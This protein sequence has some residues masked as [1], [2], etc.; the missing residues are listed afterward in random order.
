MKNIMTKYRRNMVTCAIALAFPFS[1]MADESYDA[2]K[3]QVELL[4]EQ[5]QKVQATL[6]DY[7]T[8]SATKQQVEELKQ[9]VAT[10]STEASEYKNSDSVMH[11]TGYA[12]ATYFDSENGNAAFNSVTFN[13]ILLYQYKDL[14][15]MQAEYATS[16]GEDGSSEF[17]LEYATIDYFLND[18][19][20]LSAGKFLSPI[21]QFRQNGHPS[22]IN[23]LPTSP[24]GFG[25]SQAAPNA[26]IGIQVRGG[27]PV[28]NS[29]F[30]NYAVYTANGP[31]LDIAGD[32]IEEVHTGGVTSN[33]DNKFV[34][35]GRFGFL[36]IPMMEFGVSAATGEVAGENEPNARR[37]Y[38]VYGADFKYKL[39]NL[40]L[41][42]EYIK[43]R[44]GSA[45]A[46]AAPESADW[47]AWYAQASYRFSPY[48]WEGVI[49]Y[50]D[51]NSPHN[52]QD[53]TQLVLGVNYLISS[54]A[55][56]KFAY[57]FNNGETDSLANDD[58]LQLQVSYGF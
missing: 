26:D 55:M 28:G 6:Q 52:S 39:N 29:R 43:Q 21:G 47:A 22:W 45:S 48:A 51:Y 30:L 3:A 17:E 14:I 31:T 23:K 46:S 49:R 15:L 38:K 24:I 1:A 5:L 18:Y 37:D 44:V 11:L 56:V 16:I 8:Q 25:H 19:M 12:D 33:N 20:A 50:G 9:D 32:E 58:T 7:K 34:Y 42:G 4:Q 36:P 35:G 54:N 10:V 27:V 13:P 57:N 40:R 41:L 2:L 53:Q